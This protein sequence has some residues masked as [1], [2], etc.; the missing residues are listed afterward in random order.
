MASAFSLFAE[1][2]GK[3]YN[4]REYTVKLM[5]AIN[6]TG[7]SKTKACVT[8]LVSAT[9]NSFMPFSYFMSISM[10]KVYLFPLNLTKIF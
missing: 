7:L 8:L 4:K 2:L 1:P 9:F 5:L 6:F 10:T 3:H